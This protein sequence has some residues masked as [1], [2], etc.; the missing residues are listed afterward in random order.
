MDDDRRIRFDEQRVGYSARDLPSVLAAK[1]VESDVTG[2]HRSAYDAVGAVGLAILKEERQS[3]VCVRGRGIDYAD[4]FM[5]LLVPRGRRFKISVGDK[6]GG[7]SVCIHIII[8]SFR[9]CRRQWIY[10]FYYTLCE[11]GSG[12]QK[13]N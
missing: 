9:N 10:I 7:F 12:Y 5:A 1:P 4:G 2:P 6:P 11:K 13:I 3:D 8:V